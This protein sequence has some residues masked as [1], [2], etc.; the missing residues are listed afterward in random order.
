MAKP[1][2]LEARQFERSASQSVAIAASLS[3]GFGDVAERIR[4]LVAISVRVL[5]AAATD[6]IK[7]DED[8][9]GHAPLID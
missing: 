4:A 2:R 1:Q 8:R 6:K 3:A 7:N 5:G 9:A